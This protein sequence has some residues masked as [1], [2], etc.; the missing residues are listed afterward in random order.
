MNTKR[1]QF[2][3]VTLLVVVAAALPVVAE[4]PEGLI[5]APYLLDTGLR[6]RSISFETPT[7]EPASGGKAASNLGASR[8]G[9]PARTIQPGETVQLCDIRGSGTIRHIWMTTEGEPV[10]QR[11]CMIRGW[12][13]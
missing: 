6:S 2:A 12:W 9:A 7:G 4:E 5:D 1:R 10:I 11:A 8:K 3:L 13:D